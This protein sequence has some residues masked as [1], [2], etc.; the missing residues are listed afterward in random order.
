M[1]NLSF[2]FL[3]CFGTLSSNAQ[4]TPFEIN[5]KNYSATYEECINYYKVLSAKYKGI[6]IDTR[7]ETDNGLPLHVVFL[8]ATEDF[9]PNHWQVNKQCVLLINNGIHA[10]EPDGIDASMMLA[11]DICIQIEKGTFPKNV[12]IAI[13]PVYNIA[14]MQ[15][16]KASHRP[17]QNGPAEFGARGNAQNLDLNRDFIKCDSKEALNFAYLFHEINPTI[18]IDNHVSDGADY[19]YTMTLATTQKDKLGG[20]LGKY[21]HEKMEPA[22]F[23]SMEAKRKPITPYVNVW[24]WDARKGWN[25]FFDSPR[26]SSGYATLFH[27]L[28]FVPE[29]H[30]LKPYADRVAA[31]YDLMQ[32]FIDYAAKNSKELTELKDDAITECVKQNTFPISWQNDKSKADSILFRGYTYDSI[33]SEVSG[34]MVPHYDRSKPY[35]TK[36]PFYNSYK[37]A[38]TVDA[39]IAYIIPQHNYKVIKNLAA[40]NIEYNAL[41]DDTVMLVEQYTITSYS[42]NATPYEGHHANKDIKIKASMQEIAFKKGDILV[43]TYQPGKRFL[44]ETL[45]PHAMDSYFTWNY[46]DAFLIQKEGFT[47]YAFEAKAAQ[48]LRENDSLRKALSIKVASDSAFAKNAN[49]QLE[50]VYDALYHES[51][52]NTYPIYRLV[53]KDSKDKA[54]H[55]PFNVEV[56]KMDE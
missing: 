2:I 21:L 19:Q 24:G 55:A 41:E 1:R 16:R 33:K 29:T 18:F 3:I 17:D 47:D 35:A 46:F 49:A 4:L 45:E 53:R 7:G 20:T 37:V 48:I 43:H 5:G 23:K 25:Q 9:Y 32:C 31:T 56:N 38:E 26:Y 14:G 52:H 54:E 42:S 34:L 39:P 40:N 6:K 13:I 44:V 27:T 28:A 10:G 36:V 30:M 50:F 11:R 8:N 51:R 12:A 22:I 15:L